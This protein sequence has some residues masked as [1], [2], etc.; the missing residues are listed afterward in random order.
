MIVTTNLFNPRLERLI[1][2]MS[3]RDE[4]FVV[5][6]VL[7]ASPSV[8]PPYPPPVEEG[9]PMEDGHFSASASASAS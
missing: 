8:P 5:V 7:I 9:P 2:S 6:V 1:R 3:R 4:Q